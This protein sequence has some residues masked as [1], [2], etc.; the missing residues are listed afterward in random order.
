M[1]SL[2]LLLLIIYLGYKLPKSMRRYWHSRHTLFSKYDEGIL[3]DK[4]SWYSVTPE[5]IAEHIAQKFLEKL[6]SDAVVVDIMSGA[7]G[8][9]IQF[10]KK[11]PLVFTVEMDPK[12][13]Y[14]AQHNAAIYECDNIEYIIG[15]CTKCIN[16]RWKADGVF[17][18]PPWGGPSYASKETFKMM[19]LKP[20]GDILMKIAHGISP[21]ISCFLPRNTDE[22]DIKELAMKYTED[23]VCEMEEHIVQNRVKTIAT[24]F[25]DLIKNKD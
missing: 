21:N 2:L 8:N 24:Y 17:L 25:G 14:M 6:G 16:D 20:D 23:G 11:F 18:S 1:I 12:R 13:A 7:G 10:A 15:D 4:E 9:T 22:E 5:S 3:M 19:D